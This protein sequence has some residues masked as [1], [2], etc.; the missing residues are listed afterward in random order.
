[1]AETPR[2]SPPK[3]HAA[4]A[5]FTQNVS[6]HD[7]EAAERAKSS[8]ERRR[9]EMEKRGEVVEFSFVETYRQVKT[10]DDGARKIV[11]TS[12]EKRSKDG[13]DVEG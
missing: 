5:N 3:P 12:I 10:D 4:W 8:V 11:G 2:G 9:E 6:K 7:A 13:P 1:M